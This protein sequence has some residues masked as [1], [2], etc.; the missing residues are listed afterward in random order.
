MPYRYIFQ[1]AHQFQRMRQQSEEWHLQQ[2]KLNSEKQSQ[3]IVEEY[4]R[5]KNQ[6]SKNQ[7]VDSQEW[8]DDYQGNYDG[9]SSRT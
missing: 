8:E 1:Q 4:Y 9:Q 7:L 3:S 2:S 5:I 6:Y